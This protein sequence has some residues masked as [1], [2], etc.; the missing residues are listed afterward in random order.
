M[1]IREA[2]PSDIPAMISIHTTTTGEE[3]RRNHI[4]E[5][6]FEGHA[7]VALIEDVAAG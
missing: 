2:I 3:K 4:H 6:V 1:K 5:W 7:I